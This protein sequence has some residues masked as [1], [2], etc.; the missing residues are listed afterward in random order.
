MIKVFSQEIVGSH[1]ILKATAAE[2]KLLFK[3]I[4]SII[5]IVLGFYTLLFYYFDIPILFWNVFVGTFLLSPLTWFL[6]AKKFHL[7]ARLFF[8]FCCNLYIFV[9][10]LGSG[11]QIFSECY[12]VPAMILPFLLFPTEDKKNIFSSIALT[13]AF[14]LVSIYLDLNFYLPSVAGGQSPIEFLKACNLMGSLFVTFVFLFY[15]MSLNNKFTNA[16]V[17]S[18][19]KD[20]END[21]ILLQQL[22]AAQSISKIGS[23][24]Y[25]ITSGNLIWSPEHYK[26]FEISFPQPQTELFLQYQNR[27]HPDDLPILKNLTMRAEK[28]GEDFVFDHRVVLDGGKR[29]KFVQGIGRVTKDENGK[30]ILI[31]GTCQDLTES[32]I[33][34]LENT[35]IL[36]TMSEGL[37][38]Q[39]DMG[40]IEKFNPAAL[41]ILGLSKEQLQG[42]SSTDPLW[43][44][45]KEDGAPFPGEEHP[46]MIAL[47]TKRAVRNVL[48]RVQVPN[49]NERWIK[50]NAVPY[51]SSSGQKVAATFADITEIAA[52]NNRIKELKEQNQLILKSMGI[53]I[54]QFNPTNQKI[55]WDQSLYDLY[56]INPKDFTG[57]YH[58]WESC[59]SPE[60][61]QAAIKEVQLALSGEKEFD[62]TFEIIT[63]NGIRKHIGGKGVVIRNEQKQ[64]I[65][66][67]GINWDKTKDVL[68]E[69]MIRTERTKSLHNAKL[70][71]LGELSASIAHEI[72][73]PLAV[74]LGNASLLSKFDH[75][76][77]KTSAK[78]DKITRSAERIEK[79]VKGLRKFARTTYKIE[80]KIE[81]LSEI[82][83]ESLIIT[84]LKSKLQLI[85]VNTSIPPEIKILCD[86]VEI[87]Q[88]IVNLISNAIDANRNSIDR[89]V[90]VVAFE[91]NRKVILR[92]IDSGPGISA[93]IEQ[94]IFQPF[95][96]TKD[97]G[98][99]TGLG[100]S[101]VKGILDD[102]RATIELNR[103]I[104]NTCFEIQFP[105]V[106]SQ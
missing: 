3:K 104:K 97:V 79:I 91:A 106:A 44:C 82:V 50:I 37:V 102:H 99:G 51:L 76:E 24:Q 52:S 7:T 36:K 27:I 39:N 4:L 10:G 64:P 94:K 100:L 89:W 41:E 48:M 53:G 68:A 103:N 61:K 54:W 88:V 22:E 33:N 47:R 20:T 49:Q 11:N 98:E 8:V 77:S 46:A 14:S 87:E 28:F 56:E 30:P 81:K 66:M 26:I 55:E 25:Y 40:V 105:Q 71:S 90:H 29:T 69:E 58:A 15:L 19:K 85:K 78:I 83:N 96:T 62:T 34:E 95:F 93:E 1:Q 57:D 70:A 2:A 74:I 35:S 5:W 65:N 38:I 80:H 67:F 13:V 72:N 84:E 23:W 60:A 9:S 59:L 42:R 73:N 31:S 63:K 18:L 86:S 101:I 92:V 45:L 6:E 12:F 75:D 21:K 17:A 32:K 43:R 16:F